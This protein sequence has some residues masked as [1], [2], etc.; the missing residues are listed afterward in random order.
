M[1]GLVLPDHLAPLLGAAE[2]IDVVGTSDPWV[3][4]DGWLEDTQQELR[5]LVERLGPAQAGETSS[6]YRSGLPRTLPYLWSAISY[7]PTPAPI[8]VGSYTQLAQTLLEPWYIPSDKVSPGAVQTFAIRRWDW[9]LDLAYNARGV[10]PSAVPEAL[11]VS[12]AACELLAAAPTHRDRATAAARVLRRALADESLVAAIQRASWPEVDARWQQDHT[13]VTD[14]DAA[15]LPELRGWTSLLAWGLHGFDAAHAHLTDRVS[16]GQTANQLIASMTL[17][18]GIDELPA[19]FTAILGPARFQ[20]VSAEIERLR[21]GFDSVDWLG[22]TRGWIARSLV[23]GEIDA[24]RI[25]MAMATHVAYFNVRLANPDAST[26]CPDRIGF[27]EDVRAIFRPAPTVR[28]P[29]ASKL[30]AR[31]PVAPTA[32]ATGPGVGE[33]LREDEYGDAVDAAPPPVEIG[34][35]MGELADLIGLQAVK[36]QVQRLVAEVRAEQL[37]RE[38]GMP[39]SDRSRHMVFLGNPGTAKTTVARLLAR[40]YAQLGVLDNGHLVEVSR[41]DLVGEFIGQTAPRTTAAFNRAAGGVLFV[42]EAYALVP[43]DSHRD[44]GHEAISTLLKLMED[45]RDEV[46]VIVAGYPREMQRFLTVNTGLASRFPTTIGFADYSDDELV[47]IFEL[48]RGRAGYDLDEYVT[49]QLRLL[50]PRPRPEGFGNGRFVRNVFEET[51][52]RQ[53]QRI[54][55]TGA[56]TPEEIRMLRW[57]DLPTTPPPDEKP[58]TGTGLYL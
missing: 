36:D 34:D 40:V 46:V 23:T 9:L 7:L 43:P 45:R 14:E 50:F 42:D 4:P 10:D 1:T 54:V 53:A 8:F 35:P 22:D 13:L 27:W 19:A 44:F 17:Y 20:E 33:R 58:S 6:P 24:A 47:A 5:R 48:L 21:S 39:A 29:F 57:Q 55:S 11:E 38:I 56:T 12:I 26:S 37:R 32:G 51:V 41:Q 2:F 49:Q 28:N 15:V 3:V 31:S 30:Q 52:A 18:D 25:W 16:R